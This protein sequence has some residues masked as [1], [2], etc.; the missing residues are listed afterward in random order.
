MRVLGHA[1]ATDGFWQRDDRAFVYQHE[2]R[3]RY[4]SIARTADG[5]MLV[6]FT[7]Q[8]EEQEKAEAGTLV[9]V[10]RSPDGKWWIRP[11]AV[12]TSSEGVP[13]AAGTMTALADGRI[14]A[15]FVVL[16]SGGT[17]SSLRILESRDGGKTWTGWSLIA[18]GSLGDFS[19]E[20]PAVLP[21]SEGRLVAVVTGRWL[22]H[23]MKAPQVL[24]RAFSRDG[25]RTWTR[26]EQVAVG[27]RPA[28]ARVSAEVVCA[29]ST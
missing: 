3:T 1:P 24:M 5:R 21:L 11:R 6:L 4:P 22:G 16:R 15:P 29:Y 13:R 7:R 2:G 19:F 27:T 20:Y 25:G 17:E 12:F 28:L 14:V 23:G 26:P 8:T 10:P 18:S 9:L